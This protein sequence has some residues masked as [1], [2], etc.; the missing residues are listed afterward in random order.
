MEAASLTVMESELGV[1]RSALGV[2][3][4][5]ILIT[6][7]E[8]MQRRGSSVCSSLACVFLLQKAFELESE[9]LFSRFSLCHLSC[10]LCFLGIIEAQRE[11]S[12]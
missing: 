4:F 5:L 12:V 2:S 7:G 3:V 11:L 9:L 10:P 1:S 8:D 6:K